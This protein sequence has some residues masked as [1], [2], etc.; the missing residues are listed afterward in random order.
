MAPTRQDDEMKTTEPSKPSSGRSLWFWGFAGVVLAGAATAGVWFLNHGTPL[1]ASSTQEPEHAKSDETK[2]SGERTTAKTLVEVV[3]PKPGGITRYSVMPG[4][5]HSF[6]F[7]NV[8]AKISGFLKEQYVD[9]N[10]PVKK[11]QLLARIYVPEAEKE[12][13]RDEAALRQAIAAVETAKAIKITAEADVEAAAAFVKEAE[14]NVAKFTSA[15]EYRDKQFKRIS[16]LVEQKAVPQVMLDEE[17][18]HLDSAVAAELSA[19]A[20]VLTANAQLGA[21][22]ARVLKAS[23][24]VDQAIANQ[25]F[26]KANLDKAKV[27]F[28]Y[29]EIR[30]EYD[31][32]I[33]KRTFHPG[34]FVRSAAEGGVEPLLVLARMDKM[35]VVTVV[36]DLD[37]P[38]AD[39]GDPAEIILDALPNDVIEKPVSRFADAEDPEDRTMRAEIDVMNPDR[40][41]KDGMYG[42]VRIRLALPAPNSVHLPDS[43]V[44]TDPSSR[45]KFLQLVRG[46]KIVQIPVKIGS[47]DGI[48]TEILT[49]LDPQEL[50]L[51]HPSSLY[52]EGLEVETILAEDAQI[53]QDNREP[54]TANPFKD[55]KDK[56]IDK[57]SKPAE[58]KKK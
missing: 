57:K 33:T 43:C 19:R 22:K 4:T 38:Y 24:E 27:L 36:A 31:G 25:G 20:S 12:V 46:G 1:K 26:A 5:V 9:I 30:A 15:R 40:K 6:D 41:L 53:A 18:D 32:V 2:S 54:G 50:V 47:G 35:R 52:G 13:E 39:V 3:K 49:P 42:Q 34:A 58:A 28:D 21:A 11:G 51:L 56:A 14:A 8:Y 16:E 55:V 44:Y 37:V 48:Q 7:Y 29:T 17:R 45:R 10:D 23:A